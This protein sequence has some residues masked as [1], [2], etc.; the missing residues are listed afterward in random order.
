MDPID[1]DAIVSIK[2]IQKNEIN[3]YTDRNSIYV[4]QV[5]L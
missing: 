1:Q 5:I 3:K 4:K 2:K